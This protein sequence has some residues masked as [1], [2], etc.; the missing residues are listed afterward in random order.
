MVSKY[1]NRPAF[2]KKMI[3]NNLDEEIEKGNSLLIQPDNKGK[4]EYILNTIEFPE[5][6]TYT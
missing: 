4:E 2:L 1:Y 6:K 5:I 3:D